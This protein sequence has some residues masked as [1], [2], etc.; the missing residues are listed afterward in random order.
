[1]RLDALLKDES[2]ERDVNGNIIHF[3][4]EINVSDNFVIFLM[5]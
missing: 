2:M 5:N 4:D 1:M 3:L